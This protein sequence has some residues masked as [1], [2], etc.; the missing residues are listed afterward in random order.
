MEFQEWIRWFQNGWI[1]TT[2]WLQLGHPQTSSSKCMETSMPMSEITLQYQVDQ[3]LPPVKLD[4]DS[5]IKLYVELKKWDSTLTRFSL[6][7]TNNVDSMFEHH[8]SSSNNQELVDNT[9]SLEKANLGSTSEDGSNNYIH[10][11]ELPSYIE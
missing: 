6:C 4:N 9:P 3:G 11:E 2:N 7:I 8:M 5:A 10:K 1:A